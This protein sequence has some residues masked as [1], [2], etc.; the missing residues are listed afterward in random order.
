MEDSLARGRVPCLRR[1]D[2]SGKQAR[3]WPH[4]PQLRDCLPQRRLRDVH[5][6][7]VRSRPR[8]QRRPPRRPD[9][10]WRG[11]AFDRRPS[12]CGR[13]RQPRAHLPDV[14]TA[15]VKGILPPTVGGLMAAKTRRCSRGRGPIAWT[16]R[17]EMS[18][19]RL[20][21]LASVTDTAEGQGGGRR[22]TVCYD[23]LT[24]RTAAWAR[25][26]R[27][28]IVNRASALAIRWRRSLRRLRGCRGWFRRV[29]GQPEVCVIR[30]DRSLGDV[31][32]ARRD[33]LPGGLCH[34]P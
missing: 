29:R 33:E 10:R 32:A 1:R 24:A 18:V 3:P 25:P 26:F 12:R 13:C 20:G 11:R 14:T 31:S 30:A 4:R 16:E 27:A 21:A 8:A 7:P 22:A 6:R 23:R 17:D 5:R 34:S 28:A 9:P 2:G 19:P 15:D